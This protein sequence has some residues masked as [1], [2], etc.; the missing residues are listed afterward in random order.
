MILLYDLISYHPKTFYWVHIYLL[1]YSYK[2]YNIPNLIYHKIANLYCI[3]EKYNC[4]YYQPLSYY[5]SNP[6]LLISCLLD[7]AFFVSEIT[8]IQITLQSFVIE[9]WYIKQN[10]L[11]IVFVLEKY[12]SSL[13]YKHYALKIAITRLKCMAYYMQ[14]TT[15]LWYLFNSTKR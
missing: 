8:R 9:E 14:Q 7:L 3:D 12:N 10:Q 5:N 2:L 4:P 11:R 6:Y 13:K 15:A 1:F